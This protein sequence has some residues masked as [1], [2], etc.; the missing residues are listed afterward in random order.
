MSEF[1]ALTRAVLE[2]PAED[3]VR[4]ALADWLDEHGAPDRAELIRV[5]VAL[6]LG[7]TDD[8]ERRQT[9]WCVAD[10]MARPRAHLVLPGMRFMNVWGARPVAPGVVGGWPTVALTVS[11]D[12]GPDL[13]RVHAGVARGWWASVALSP[14]PFLRHAPAIFA[15]H[16]V[17]AVILRRVEPTMRTVGGVQEWGFCSGSFSHPL[18]NNT[19]EPALFA[20]LRRGSLW[21]TYWRVYPSRGAALADLSD[22]CVARGRR[23]A[24][25]TQLTQPV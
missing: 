24:G 1:D 7:R 9:D 22:A 3:T 13:G 20:E 4:L 10:K 16:P 14:V 2:D 11:P 6:A 17:T 15:A 19:V 18:A 23:L 12:G 25:L 21:A 5:Q 8:L